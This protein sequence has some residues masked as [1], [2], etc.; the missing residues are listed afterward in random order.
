[1]GSKNEYKCP[2][3]NYTCVVSGKSDQ[4]RHSFSET[5]LCTNC[6]LVLDISLKGKNN[7]EIDEDF[8]RMEFFSQ[9]PK[10]PEMSPIKKLLGKEEDKKAYHKIL[11]EYENAREIAV[12][13]YFFKSIEEHSCPHCRGL[14][15]VKWYEKKTCPKCASTMKLSTFG[16]YVGLMQYAQIFYL[17]AIKFSTQFD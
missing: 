1:M 2:T 11:R 8:D 4:G 3:C 10:A 7:F 15:L 14:H 6:K 16:K 13:A 9:Y 12:R 5:C 17:K